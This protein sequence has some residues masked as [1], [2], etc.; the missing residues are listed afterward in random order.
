V[1]DHPNAELARS[2]WEAVGRA[3]PETLASL[4]KKEIVWHAPGRGARGGDFHG[5][6]AVI[7]HLRGLGEAAEELNSRLV[8]VMGGEDRAAAVYHA[9]GRR[10]GRELDHDVVLLFRIE[11]GLIAE[12]WSVPFDQRAA[13][14]FWA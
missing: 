2:A 1:K 10:Y 5:L 14:Q 4:C 9:T 13:E 11:D 8:A 12:V 7:D 3:D 6:E